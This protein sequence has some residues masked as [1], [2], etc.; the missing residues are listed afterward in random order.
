MAILCVL[1]SVWTSPLIPDL[2][3]VELFSCE[4]E[5][6]LCDFFRDM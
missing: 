6:K 1:S 4:E 2:M 3:E 5:K